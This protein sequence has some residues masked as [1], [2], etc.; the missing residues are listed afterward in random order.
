MRKSFIAVF[1]SLMASVL[2]QAQLVKSKGRGEIVYQGIFSQGSAE[3]RAAIS[4]AKKSA[5]TRYA[6]TMEPARYELYRKVEAEIFAHLD[7]YIPDYTQIDQQ[8]DRTSKRFVVI[9]EASINTT[10]IENTIQKSM[11]SAEAGGEHSNIT[12]I[13]VARELASRKVFDAKKTSVE[14]NEGSQTVAEKEAPAADG[15]S[16]QSS[17]ETNS[18]AKKTVG[19]NT[20]IKADALTYRVSTVAEVDSAVNAVLSKARYETVDP[21]DAGLDLEKFKADFSGG[22]DISAATRSEAIS[23]LRKNDIRYMAIANMDVGL[24]EKDEVS[25]MVRVY[26]TVT[27][28]ITYLPP[29]PPE[30]DKTQPRKLPKAVASI[31]GKPFAGLGPNPQVARTNALNEAAARSATELTDQL[32]MKN[33]K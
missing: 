22:N 18:V 30:G 9:I 16:T 3:E 25:G 10:L 29:L 4:E 6:A 20:E 32:R 24:P 11:G 14:I 27:A 2:C 8:V 23:I 13:F 33:I 5:I 1:F 15:Q 26:V 21:N 12:F 28:K 17:M 31:A 19:G 7:D